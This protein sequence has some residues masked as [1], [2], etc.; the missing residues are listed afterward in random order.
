MRSSIICVSHSSIAQPVALAASV[1][2]PTVVDVDL[3]SASLGATRDLMQEATEDPLVHGKEDVPIRAAQQASRVERRRLP[4]ERSTAVVERRDLE[5]QPAAP[6]Q[7][8]I[9]LEPQESIRFVRVDGPA[10]DDICHRA[11]FGVAA[12][13]SH[14]HT[15]ETEVQPV[16]RSPEKVPEVPP[17]RSA[18]PP[19]W[20][21]DLRWGR[22]QTTGPRVDLLTQPGAVVYRLRQRRPQRRRCDLEPIECG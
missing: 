13:A 14:A 6:R 9:G 21:K 17:I 16:S 22:V 15:A 8:Q 5:L 7:L 2:R 12:A 11:V 1:R 10:V 19:D 3:N 20:S 4:D 18:N